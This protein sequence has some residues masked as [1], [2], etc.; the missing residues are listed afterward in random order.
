MPATIHAMPIEGVAGRLMADLLIVSLNT[1]GAWIVAGILAAGGIYLGSNFSFRAAWEWSQERSIQL[2]AWHDRYR[3]WQADRADRRAEQ[4]AIRA[5]E[6]GP[7]EED[8]DLE[9]GTRSP[10]IFA[11]MFGLMRR[12]KPADEDL[13]E[14][15]PAFQRLGA[16]R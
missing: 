7:A 4:E 11:R 13:L 5:A 3:N 9:A 14:D 12:R 8:E 6:R 15:V 1:T 10:G 16:R 2:A